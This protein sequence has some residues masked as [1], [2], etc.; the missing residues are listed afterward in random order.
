MAWKSHESCQTSAGTMQWL[1]QKQSEQ[2]EKTH[3][4][5]EK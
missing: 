5:N 4:D 1:I 3:Y 2:T